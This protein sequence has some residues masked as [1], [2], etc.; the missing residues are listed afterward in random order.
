M[1]VAKGLDRETVP[2][3]KLTLL[4][5]DKGM[6]IFVCVRICAIGWKKGCNISLSGKVLV[7]IYMQNKTKQNKTHKTKQNKIGIHK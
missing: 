3:H 1:T 5:T 4:A 7:C 6:D 2:F